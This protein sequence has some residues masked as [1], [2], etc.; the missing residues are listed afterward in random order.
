MIGSTI[1]PITLAAFCGLAMQFQASG[2]NA[3]SFTA[4]A[5]MPQRM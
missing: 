5:Q 2:A 4:E 1:I 3:Q